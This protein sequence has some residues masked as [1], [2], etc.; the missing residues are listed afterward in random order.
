MNKAAKIIVTIVAI[1]IFFIVF[2][3]INAGR[4]SQGF[5]TPGILGVVAMCVLIA[6]L[7]I[8]W[9]KD[10]KDNDNKKNE[11]NSSSILQK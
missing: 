7:R 6:A 3:L 11:S 10:N 8:L 9:K 1:V 5:H 4:Q 2:G